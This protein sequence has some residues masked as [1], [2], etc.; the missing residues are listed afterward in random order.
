MND[1]SIHSEV[2]K[3]VRAYEHYARKAVQVQLTPNVEGVIF[4][5]RADI[6]EF[7]DNFPPYMTQIDR[8]LAIEAGLLP[9]QGDEK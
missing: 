3:Y 2:R 1:K 7:V 4:P 6:A 9:R 5:L 8:H